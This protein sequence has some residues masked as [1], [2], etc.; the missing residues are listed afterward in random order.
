MNIPMNTQHL[1]LQISNEIKAKIKKGQYKEGQK[2]STED[3]LCSEYNVSRITV[4]KAIQLLCDQNILVKKHGK[5]T[6]VALPKAIDTMSITQSFSGYCKRNDMKPSSEV[7]SKKIIKA[8]KTISDKLGVEIDDDIIEIKR[9][10]FIDDEATVFEIDY[11]RISYDFLMKKKLDNKSLLKTLLS[12][13]I[14]NIYKFDHVVSVKNGDEFIS[15]KLNK[16][17]NFCF[18][19]VSETVKNP[20]NEIIYYNEQYIVSGKYNYTVSTLK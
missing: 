7:I 17:N 15:E 19:H 9:L 20:E 5:G 12:E 18:L 11:F 16:N 8:S 3:E 4:R 6:F 1:Y 13:N 14:T 2:I 10:L